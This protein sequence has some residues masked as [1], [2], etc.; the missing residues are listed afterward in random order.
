MKYISTYESFSVNETMDMFTLPVDPIPG[1]KDVISDIGQWFTQTGEFLW[2]KLTS[3]IDWIKSKISIPGIKEYFSQ[4]F[5]AIGE[6]SKIQLNKVT[7]LF[8]DKEYTKVEWSDLNATTVKNLYQKITT[9]IKEFTT[10]KSWSFSD[11][12]DKLKSEEGVD[13]KSLKLKYY[14]NTTLAFLGKSILS[15]VIHTILSKILI[16]LGLSAGPVVATIASVV[17]LVLFIWSSKKK[18]NLE[19][20]VMKDVRDVPGYKPQSIIGR[21]TGWSDFTKQKVEDY[22]DFTQG[23]S[24]FQKLYFQRLKEQKEKIKSEELNFS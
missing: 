13:D 10:D 18:V 11:D 17:I 6:L 15:A 12:K 22:Q 7:N 9:S 14:I 20:K 23:E 1:M 5:E 3:F 21:I 2:N 4:L 24:Q 16:A 19:I 8:F